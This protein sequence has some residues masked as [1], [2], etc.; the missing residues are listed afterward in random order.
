MRGCQKYR[1]VGVCC[2]GR[3]GVRDGWIGILT[4]GVRV[5]EDN[6]GRQSGAARPD[7]ATDYWSIGYGHA[8]VPPQREP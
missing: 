2:C 6:A 3:V 8:M 5:D 7:S 4:V 1:S